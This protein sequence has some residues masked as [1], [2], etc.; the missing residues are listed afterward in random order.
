MSTNRQ[1]PPHPSFLALDRLS[2][3]VGSASQVS[4]H[5]AGCELCQQHLRTLGHALPPAALPAAIAAIEGRQRRLR[6][7]WAGASLLAAAACLMLVLGRG[8]SGP[9][10]EA[11]AVYVGAKGFASV[12]IYVK[13]GSSTALWDGKR[14]VVVGDRLRIKLDSADFRRVQVYSVKDAKSPELLYSGSLTPGQ[15]TL[16]D[17]WEVDGEPGDERLVVALTNDPVAPD[18]ERWLKG[19]AAAGVSVHSFVL[20]KSAGV[21]PD[22]SAPGR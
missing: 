18:W 7:W 16:P 2:L 17:A 4:E 11:P 1:T 13:R 19:E 21:T 3:D 8:A 6:A 14:P 15:S 10:T 9:S 12:W 22:A 20:P 5:V